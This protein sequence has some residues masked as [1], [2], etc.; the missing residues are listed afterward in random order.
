MRHCLVLASLIGIGSAAFASDTDSAHLFPTVRSP[1]GISSTPSTLVKRK[2]ED[3]RLAKPTRCPAA[4][5]LKTQVASGD[6]FVRFVDFAQDDPSGVGRASLDSEF[7]TVAPEVV[8]EGTVEQVFPIRAPERAIELSHEAIPLDNAP[9]ENAESSPREPKRFATGRTSFGWIAGTNDQLGMLEL[10]YEPLARARFDATKPHTFSADASYG[11]KWLTGPN[12]TDLPPQLFNV[13]INLGTTHRINQRL[14]IDAMLSPG[15]YTDFSNKGI[16]AFRL[17][18]HVVSYS[19]SFGMCQT[20]LGVTDLARDDIHLLPVAGLIFASPESDLRLD[21]VFPK[22]R[23]AW[24]CSRT[25]IEEGWWYL[26]GELGGGSYAISRA[27]R[28][29]DVVTYR[30]YR[31]TTGFETRRSKGHA[32][33]LEAGW[34]FNRFVSYRSDQGNYAPPDSIMIRI[35]SDY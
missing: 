34:I 7:E 29:Y 20:V 26:G 30:D 16:E 6:H 32:T 23:I 27:D 28:A 2:S 35:S 13:L 9:R 12:S 4:F 15:W 11:A 21:L 8:D 25:D 1:W 3:R 24:R 22:P 17:P 33:R 18:W 5:E 14:I 31:L 19:Q 10:D